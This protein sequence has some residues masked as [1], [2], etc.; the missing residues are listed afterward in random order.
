MNNINVFSQRVLLI[1]ATRQND[2]ELVEELKELVST[3]GGEVVDTVYQNNNKLIH[4][5][6]LGKGKVEEV[7]LLVESLEID[8][9]IF[10]EQLNASQIKYLEDHIKVTVIDRTMLILDIFA[11]NART[12]EGKLQVEA[13]QLKYMLPR[14]IGRDNSLSRLGGGIGTRG[15][16]ES[17]LESDR[18][19]VKSKL[20]KLQLQL[21]ELDEIRKTASKQ[22]KKNQVFTVAVVGY[23]NAGKST[24][25]NKLTKSNVL[26]QDKLFA[27]LDPTARKLFLPSGKSVLMFD[28]VGFIRNLP[29]E[30]IAAFKSTLSTAVEADLILNICD[31]S[32][33]YV[34]EHNE[35]SHKLLSSLNC[36][37]PIINVFNKADKMPDSTVTDGIVI[38]ALTGQGLTKL[39][40]T[41]DKYACVNYVNISLKFS[42]SEYSIINSIRQYGEILSQN[43]EGNDIIV[44]AR[45]DNTVIYRF[46]EYIV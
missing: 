44:K 9:V 16:G 46:T 17:K 13:A 3:A 5:S 27:T 42:A 12:S 29:H 23:T 34:T 30:L 33:P 31:F 2:N 43:Y 28:T 14:L 32:S 26:S 4:S 10:N 24:L 45:I 21:N 18:R 8:V 19:L 41:I 1:F 20:N 38:S 22:R 6:A 25:F 7:A 40:E 15:P 11:L 37:S 36:Q 35:I 39:L